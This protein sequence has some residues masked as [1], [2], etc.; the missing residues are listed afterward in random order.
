M[1][2]INNV[3][4]N[5]KRPFEAGP[6]RPRLALVGSPNVGKS[7]LFNRLTNSYLIVSNYPGTTVEVSRGQARIGEVEFEVIDTP[8]L[9]SLLPLTEEERVARDILRL[10]RPELVLHVI[11]AKNLERMLPL[12]LQLR[13]AGLSL[14]LVLNIMD[15]AEKLGLR[16]D[17]ERLERE[18]GLPAAATVSTTGRGIDKLKE[19]ILTAHEQRKT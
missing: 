7:S 15:D 1:T 9:Y 3:R 16:I 19:I 13:E 17:L 14:V 4:K 6:G 10:E 8:G 18:L 5:G 12:T 2:E 11:D